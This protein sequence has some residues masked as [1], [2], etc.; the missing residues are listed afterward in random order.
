M[1][2]VDCFMFDLVLI[3]L[4][5]FFFK[6][7][8][9]YELRISDWSSDVCSSDLRRP[10]LATLILPAAISAYSQLLPMLNRRHAPSIECNRGFSATL[11]R[12]AFSG[13]SSTSIV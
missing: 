12:P 4:F 7:K 10:S 11:S 8:T 5:F 1:R 6:Q 3:F 2:T 13:F 9:A